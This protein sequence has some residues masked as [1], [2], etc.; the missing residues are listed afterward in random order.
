MKREERLSETPGPGTYT[1]S[2]VISMVKSKGTSVR[3]ST[4]KRPDNFVKTQGDTPGPGNYMASTGTF[5]KSVRGAA[6]MGAKYKPTRNYNPGPGSYNADAAKTKLRPGTST[7]KI[8][9]TK[10]KDLWIPE[11]KNALGA[12][13]PG[14]HTQSYSSFSQTKNKFSFAGGRKEKRNDNPGPGQYNLPD[15]KLSQSNSAAV[16]IGLQKKPEL[17]QDSTKNDLPGPGNYMATTG[18]FGKSVKGAA[19]MGAKYK[20][21]RN[22]N[23]GPGTYASNNSPMKASTASVRI[24]R[25][26]RKELWENEVKNQAPGPG[27][28]QE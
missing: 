28:Y 12:P 11:D 25:A 17:W 21:E 2:N 4:A 5:G 13:G 18:T 15:K 23:P 14:T 22:D 1:N 16:K 27:N 10:R 7:A 3:I 19:T 6:T 20:P 26:Q 8:G 9:T 24:S